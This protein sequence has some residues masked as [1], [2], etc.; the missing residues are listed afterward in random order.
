MDDLLKVFLGETA[1]CLAACWIAVDELRENPGDSAALV[2]LLRQDWIPH[3][4]TA[5]LRALGDREV[6][7]DVLP[8]V[9]HN[10]AEQ[11]APGR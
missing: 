2:E 9:L 8:H 10:V 5:H 1:E 11:P 6:S 4:A 3:P 7:D